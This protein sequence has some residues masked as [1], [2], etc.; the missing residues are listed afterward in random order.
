M[1]LDQV[2]KT[3]DWEILRCEVCSVKYRKDAIA[4]FDEYDKSM[5]MRLNF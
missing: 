1:N 5:N 2:I 4:H 3:A